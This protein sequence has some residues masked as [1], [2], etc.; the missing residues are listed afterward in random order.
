ML[1]L[2]GTDIVRVVWAAGAM[3][4]SAQADSE[5][6]PGPTTG[7]GMSDADEWEGWDMGDWIAGTGVN[8]EDAEAG[9]GAEAGA[10]ASAR[11]EVAAPEE[12]AGAGAG[13][14]EGEEAR[15]AGLEASDEALEQMPQVCE[16]DMDAADGIVAK[17]RRRRVLVGKRKREDEA[18]RL[19]DGS[20]SC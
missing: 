7:E 17:L 15:A 6:E 4:E 10:E 20:D 11:A 2:D 16:Q 1:M 3:H 5:A 19:S 13:A 14:E 12:S 9:A 18:R 8:L